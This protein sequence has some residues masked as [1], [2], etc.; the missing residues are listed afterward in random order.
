MINEINLNELQHKAFNALLP[1]INKYSVYICDELFKYFDKNI[2][3]KDSDGFLLKKK[4]I[5]FNIEFSEKF[6][7]YYINDKFSLNN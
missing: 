7:T 4:L 2:K 6:N 3:L 5:G 1:Y